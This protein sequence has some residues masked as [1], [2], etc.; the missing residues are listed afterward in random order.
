M[1]MNPS[2]K[3][4]NIEGNSSADWI[5]SSSSSPAYQTTKRYSLDNPYSD[6]SPP[7]SPSNISDPLAAHLLNLQSPDINVRKSGIEN[8]ISILTS[9]D[10]EKLLK[11]YINTIVVLATESPFEEI[12]EAFTNLLKSLQDKYH[13][14]KQK[15]SL[16]TNE[17]QLPSLTSEDDYTRKLFQDVFLQ[18]GRV[19]HIIRV[20][21]WHPQYLER[22]LASYNKVMR[23]PGPI[24]LPWRNYIGILASARYNC[25]Y[26]VSLQEHEFL[27]NNGDPKWL[28]GVEYIPQKLK[29]LLN[30][31]QLMA[32]QPWLLPKL[33]I[34][35]LLKGSD[36]WSIAELV[37]A[38]VLICTFLSL[39]GFVFCC[40]VTPEFGLSE[41]DRLNFSLN[42]SDCE[43]EDTTAQE[44]TE[45]V[46]E[47]LK[48]RKNDIEE[49]ELEEHD[50]Q[51]DFHNA[52]MESDSTG[53]PLSSSS[54]SSSSSNTS[55]NHHHYHH[56]TASSS[57]NGKE[58]V[59]FSRYTSGYPLSH[60]DFDVSSR[61]YTI[62]SAQEYSWKEHGYELVSRFFPDA[63]PLL[64]EE[65]SFVYTMTYYKFNNST[66]IDTLPFRRA[67]WYY[68][69]R[70]KGMCHDD[71]N[72]Q[73][74][75][76]FLS[77]SLKNYVKKAVCFP[78]TIT[79][80]DFAKLGYH[81]KPDEKCHLALLAVCSHKQA[82]LLYDYSL[83][84]GVTKKNQ[85]NNF[86]KE[87]G[88]V[89]ELSLSS[90]TTHFISNPANIVNGFKSKS[91]YKLGCAVL[92][93]SFIFDSFTT[94]NKPNIYPYLYI[95]GKPANEVLPSNFEQNIVSSLQ[96]SFNLLVSLSNIKVDVDVD[97]NPKPTTP[98][99]TTTIEKVVKKE[100][101]YHSKVT[102]PSPSLSITSFKSKLDTPQIP[103][104]PT[105]SVIIPTVSTI[106]DTP[107]TVTTSSA[108]K[109]K[110]EKKKL[111]QNE[112]KLQKQLDK[113]KQ[114]DEK[115]R[116]KDEK[117]K[118]L[119]EEKANK[120]KL[121]SERRKEVLTKLSKPVFTSSLS[122]SSNSVSINS[123]P[124]ESISSYI[125][126][127]KA[128][129]NKEAK[130]LERDRK[131]AEKVHK[132][133]QAQKA[134]ELKKQ[135][136]IERTN[137]YHAKVL[138]EQ[139][140]LEDER[141][142]K[143]DESY[144]AFLLRQE[145]REKKKIEKQNENGGVEVVEEEIIHQDL[146]KIFVG[147]IKFDDLEK[148]R[149]KP[150]EKTKIVKKRVSYLLAE[151]NQFGKVID[152]NVRPQ[153]A[154]QDA[155]FFV[156]FE[157]SDDAQKAAKYFSVNENRK[158]TQE[159]IKN[160]V[161]QQNKS[162]H[163]TPGKFYVRL[164]RS[165]VTQ[166]KVVEKEKRIAA[167]EKAKIEKEIKDKE[168]AEWT[169]VY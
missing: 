12:S 123:T 67:V 150:S 157:S 6:Y 119:A 87:N 127:I 100:V 34:E 129:D 141:K 99:T 101:N 26:M 39:S 24:P 59:D 86:I 57:S 1:G 166:Q 158:S 151:F 107:T 121:E 32:H 18:S 102:K 125:N 45:K 75:N 148:V 88:G 5:I 138:D 152:R 108:L 41:T 61:E 131:R 10:N 136:K 105:V 35:Y 60:K 78:D 2:T 134:L 146:R 28:Q 72:Y 11:S 30:V 83:S 65:F 103:S 159:K 40:G 25:S 168:D 68:V 77:I 50:R 117:L 84:V 156:T 97:S 163:I 139:K 126:Q 169:E 63:A 53:P 36:A 137:A 143:Q 16:F 142:R 145:K 52:G 4:Q 149:L 42:D 85:Y 73:E 27:L 98:I 21:G 51:Q 144:Q 31:I 104:T 94:G 48:K 147:G 116:E 81:L 13:I 20:L 9:P 54:S 120:I 29:N 55:S 109:E 161:Q 89:I 44:N 17:S 79:R 113:Q 112:I 165:S 38:M 128:K 3:G 69:Q 76:M 160:L 92:L 124:I 91:A 71:Y 14:P 95:D 154:L 162:I 96:Q 58:C 122:D 8:I 155:S 7:Q 64:D 133:E 82:A 115:K 22:F 19:N 93:E 167:E 47:L 114:L 132:Q 56:T 164:V 33:D 118:K 110:L 23:E 62:F 106:N 46:M 49:E 74:V 70:V 130:A 90:K 66:D 135:Q 43:I 15:T 153:V 111:E 37:H 80:Q 140:Q